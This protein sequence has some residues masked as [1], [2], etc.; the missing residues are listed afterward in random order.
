MD[1]AK[2]VLDSEDHRECYKLTDRLSDADTEHWQSACTD[3]IKKGNFA[4]VCTYITK[5]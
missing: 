3:V 4:K 1:V 5:Y 2:S